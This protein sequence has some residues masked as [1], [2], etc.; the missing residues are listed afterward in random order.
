MTQQKDTRSRSRGLKTWSSFGNLG[1]R[2]TEYEILTH[3]MNHTTGDV[4]LELGPDVNGNVWLREHRDSSALK[5]PDWDAFR[6]PDAVT[7]GSYVAMQDDQETYVEGL[8]EQFDKENHDAGL[9]PQALDHLA[10]VVTPGRY[11]GHAEQMLSAYV[12]QLAP[13]SFI[14][15]AATFQTADQLRRVQLIAYR[16]T[17]LASEHEGRTFGTGER[18]VWENHPAWQPMRRAAELALAEFDW[19]RAVVA[20][21]LVVKP[22]AD[23]LF[24]GQAARELAAVG[25]TL[26]SLI[27]ENL[28]RDAE[29]SQRWGGALISFLCDAG[30]GNA[31]VLQG[32]LD[33]W[34]PL[35]REAITAAAD[36]IAAPGGRSAQAVAESAMRSWRGFVESTGL[37]LPG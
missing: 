30:S 19:D 22:V 18:Q 15:T 1:R 16:T 7:Y 23:I 17:Q 37:K 34:A 25:A 10:V 13:G 21:Q 29:R 2:P 26:D 6:D 3:G 8:L 35:G 28:W 14:A 27:A 32:H 31:A 5:V 24:L 11:L 4:A 9:S 33:Q 20:T 36:V 12:Q